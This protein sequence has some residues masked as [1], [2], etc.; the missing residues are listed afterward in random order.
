MSL[1]NG[2]SA[3]FWIVDS[4]RRTLRNPLPEFS[5]FKASLK[6]RS[7]NLSPWIP[8]KFLGGTI[9][10]KKTSKNRNMTFAEVALMTSK[11]HNRS[12]K[13]LPKGT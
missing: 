9:Q 10:Q 13:M 5:I 3:L 7:C 12:L 8:P 4:E 1:R 6:G 11:A 2:I